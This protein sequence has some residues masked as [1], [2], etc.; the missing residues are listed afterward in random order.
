MRQPRCVPQSLLRAPP[1]AGDIL[2]GEHTGPHTPTLAAIY[3]PYLVI[4]LMLVARMALME[5][6]FPAAPRGRSSKGSKR[7]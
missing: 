2:F 3:A 4:P 5:D 6:P 7:A 1:A